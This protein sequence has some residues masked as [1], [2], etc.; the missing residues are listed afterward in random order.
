MYDASSL[1]VPSMNFIASPVH[2]G[3]FTHLFEKASYCFSDNV[4]TELTLYGFLEAPADEE[5]GSH[6]NFRCD[7]GVDVQNCT[8]S[9]LSIF[10]EF[11][12]RLS[13]QIHG[14]F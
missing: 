6:S 10:I 13:Y 4:A 3:S 7:S 12:N 1:N 8:R 11:T 5:F 14:E 9:D 2:E